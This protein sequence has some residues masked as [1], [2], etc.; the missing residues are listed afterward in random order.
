MEEILQGDEDRTITRP[1]LLLDG[2]VTTREML[3]S[4]KPQSQRRLTGY[5]PKSCFVNDFQQEYMTP[6]CFQKGSIVTD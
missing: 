1:E 2:S 4:V 3:V 6:C 5:L